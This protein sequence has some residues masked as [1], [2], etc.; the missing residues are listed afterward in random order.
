MRK[1]LI[2]L[3][4]FGIAFGFVEA[5][6]VFYLR[7]IFHYT[8][9]Y[10]LSDYK[11]LFNTGIITFI[12]PK[13]P[14]LNNTQIN[15]AELQ[16]EIA[17]I[18]MLL[19]V[20][21]MSATKWKQRLGAFLITFAF[22]DIFYYVFLKYLTGWPKSLLDIDVYFLIPVPWI[23]PVITPIIISTI[24]ATIGTRLYLEPKSSKTTRNS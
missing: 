17:T 1:K 20:S 7:E 23:G 19:T 8:D 18:I 10:L 15:F 5:T 22:W 2:G 16:R 21:Y 3:I 14:I 11:V 6:V 12:W 13:V 9:N 24:L 4:I